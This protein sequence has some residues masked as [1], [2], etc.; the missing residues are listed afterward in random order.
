[1]NEKPIFI[2]GA[3]RS[4][5][6]LLAAMLASHSRLSCGP[7]THFFRWLSNTDVQQLT[8]PDQWPDNALE[9]V[10]SISRTNFSDD[11]RSL[12]IDHYQLSR[13]QIRTHLNIQSPSVAAMLSSVTALYMQQ[14][15]KKRWAEK[16]PDHIEYLQL[17]RTFFPQAQII[18]ILRDPRDVILSLSKV[19]WGV[20][21]LLEGAIFWKR[22]DDLSRNFFEI[23]PHSYSLRFE[24]LILSPKIELEKLC[25]FLGE[26]F[27]PAMLD[28]SQTGKQLN[29]RNVAWK[30][31]SSQP[32]DRSR[33]EVWRSE[34]TDAQ[35][36]MIE[37]L[38]G[39]RLTAYG[40]PLE[41]T[42]PRLGEVFPRFSTAAKYTEALE[43]VASKGVRFWKTSANEPST[44]RIYLGDPE[45]N[46]WL[47]HDRSKKVRDTL[48]LSARICRSISSRD[49]EIYWAAE[50]PDDAWSGYCAFLLKSL[51]ARY[52]IAPES[53]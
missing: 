25:Q 18:R 33:I 17:I 11:Q 8:A 44:V 1:M 31:K 15:G 47:N 10:C 27:E 30:S 49:E 38:L 28:T 34:L 22:Q 41:N 21:S 7:E 16:T 37:S 32:I 26:A 24:D 13:D 42:F 3:P 23:D 12:L 48:A 20:A 5:T 14:M 19:S 36:K 35:N 52:K 2:V 51:L 46:H 45:S 4:G 39:D 50:G 6:T 9:F 29:S 43:Q 40:Y 53:R